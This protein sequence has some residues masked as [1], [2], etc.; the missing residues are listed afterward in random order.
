MPATAD[1]RRA[2]LTVENSNGKIAL[3]TFAHP[4]KP[5]RRFAMA[6]KDVFDGVDTFQR[7]PFILEWPTNGKGVPQGRLRISGVTREVL[8]WLD[9]V[10]TPPPTV[11]CKFVLES[12]PT[13]AEESWS[14][15][16]I[17]QVTAKMVTVEASFSQENFASDPYPSKRMTGDWAH[18]LNLW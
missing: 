11:S 1:G 2:V 12:N 18:W 8:D 16:D 6:K 14:L 5:T 10:D 7:M 9:G 3:L 15:F 17:Q 13:V 4:D